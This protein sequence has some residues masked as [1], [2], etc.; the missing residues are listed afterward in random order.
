MKDDRMT[1]ALEAIARRGVPENTNLW[2]KISVQLGE[3]KS[4]MQTICTRPLLMIIII[5]LALLILTGI[6]YAVGMATGYIPGV[7]FVDQNYPIRVLAG[8]VSQTQDGITVTIEQVIVDL[9]RTVVIYKTE[10]LTIQAANS[11][12]EGGG[13]PF[14]SEHLLR[15]P[16]GSTLKETSDLGYGGTPEPLVNNIHA[17][18]GWP[19]YVALGWFIR[20]YHRR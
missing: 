1:D 11:K 7:G 12:G 17:E 20:P 15:L 18:G 13:N 9:E 19:N 5:I 2:P 10:G 14:G 6:A 4:L 16:D 3:R 8:P